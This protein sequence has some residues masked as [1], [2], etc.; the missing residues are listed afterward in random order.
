MSK[1]LRNSREVLLIDDDRD[2][3]EAFTEALEIEGYEVTSMSD[4]N[5]ALKLLVDANYN[6]CLIL[7][8]LIMPCMDGASFVHALRAHARFSETPTVLFTASSSGHQIV[9]DVR[10]MVHE[11]IEKPSDIQKLLSVVQAHCGEAA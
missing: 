8:D 3:R 11:V 1:T 4:A 2:I 6:P 5:E 10:H 7:V 9:R